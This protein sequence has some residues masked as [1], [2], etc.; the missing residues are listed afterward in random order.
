M[1]PPVTSLPGVGHIFS[2]LWKMY[3]RLNQLEQVLAPTV[4]VGYKPLFDGMASDNHVMKLV[5]LAM[6]VG[7]IGLNSFEVKQKVGLAASHNP[8]HVIEPLLKGGGWAY[9]F[10]ELWKHLNLLN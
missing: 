7:A 10:V 2:F 4:A 5:V 1:L 8:L 9:L 3:S 6:V